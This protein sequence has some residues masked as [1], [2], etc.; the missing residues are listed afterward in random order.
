MERKILFTAS[1]YSHIAHFHRPYLRAFAELGYLVDV[2][3]GGTPMEIPE[4]RQVIHLPFEKSMTAPSNFAAARQLRRRVQREGYALVSTHTSLAAFFTRL[5]AMG[6]DTTVVNTCHG[7]LFDEDTPA[8]K[9]SVLLAAERLTAARTDLLLTMNRCDHQIAARYRLG[10][11]IL[12]IPGIGVDFSR[13]DA[14]TPEMG[15][16]LRREWNIPANAFVLIYPAEFSARKHQETCI[17]AMAVLPDTV[18]LLLPGIGALRESCMELAVQLGVV[19]RIRF[20]GY[21]TDM[22]P[23]YQAADCA[24][25]S[26]RSEGLPFNVMEAMYVGLPVVASAVKGHEDLVREGETGLLFPW[27]DADACARA[28]GSLAAAPKLCRSMGRAG[29]EAA[30]AY[31]LE[32]VLPQVMEAYRTVLP[33]LPAQAP[34]P[35]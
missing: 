34:R 13:F 27:G 1:T 15:H 9:R 23:W 4:A 18:Y 7:Y 28:V 35:L 33:E 25:T 32:R 21:I 31:R 29:A 12:N 30:E 3:C 24:V 2:A 6:L 14:C 22:G 16:A 20:P 5:A 26:S 17:R 19:D 11:A 10:R 8:A